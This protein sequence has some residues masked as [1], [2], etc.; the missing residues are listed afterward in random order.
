MALNSV[1]AAKNKMSL[2]FRFMRSHF[3]DSLQNRDI[4]FKSD[5][6]WP[7]FPVEKEKVYLF[8]RDDVKVFKVG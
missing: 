7:C 5:Y 1:S 2:P 3:Y 6:V 4:N 8:K